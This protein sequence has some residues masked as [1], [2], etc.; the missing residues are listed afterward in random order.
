VSIGNGWFDPIIQYQAY[1]NFSVFPGNTYDYQPFNATVQ[2]QWYN[3]LY[4]PGNCLD[5]LRDCEAR[6]LNTV[7]SAADDFCANLVENVYDKY[8]SRDEYDFREL[9]PDPFPY[10][11][12]SKYLNKPEVQAAIGAYQNWSS[13]SH[14]VG[15]LFLILLWHLPWFL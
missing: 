7:C 5:Q 12:Y 9:T 15:K 6:G 10:G 11:H 3:N 2:A 13:S 4:G 14:A 8:S 1:Y